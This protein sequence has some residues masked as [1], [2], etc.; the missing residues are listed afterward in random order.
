[1]SNKSVMGISFPPRLG[2]NGQ[3]VMT[4]TT[5]VKPDH[6]EEEMYVFL[7]TKINERVIELKEGTDSLSIVFGE[8]NTSLVTYIKYMLTKELSGRFGITID[9]NQT[10]VTEEEDDKG[11]NTFK[12]MLYYF[13]DNFKG[14]MFSTAFSLAKGGAI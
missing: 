5:I 4:E 11:N 7:Q 8:L 13:I 6:L 9:K 3:V 14:Q 1:M 12:V 2:T 10:V